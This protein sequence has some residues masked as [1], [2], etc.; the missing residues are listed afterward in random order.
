[1][2]S[3]WRAAIKQVLAELESIPSLK[4]EQ[5]AALEAFKHKFTLHKRQRSCTCCLLDELA[6]T[7]CYHVIR[8]VDLIGWF[9][10]SIT[11]IGRWFIQSATSI[12]APS[13]KALQ[14]NDSRWKCWADANHSIWRIQV[15]DRPTWQN[16]F[17]AAR[18]RID[19]WG[20]SLSAHSKHALFYSS[21]FNLIKIINK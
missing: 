4:D 20:G 14:W 10:P 17:A 18:G 21:I 19:F 8:F 12:F 15:N 2:W 1:M 6:S 9:G 3:R 13:Q 5:K 7:L 16:K 11:N